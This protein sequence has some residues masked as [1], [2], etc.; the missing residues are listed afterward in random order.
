M[1]KQCCISNSGCNLR[2]HRASQLSQRQQEKLGLGQVAAV[3]PFSYSSQPAT[4]PPSISC[5]LP[6]LD[7]ETL[8]PLDILI[9]NDPTVKLIQ[10]DDNER[11]HRECE[12]Q[13][14]TQEEADY[15]QAIA[16]SLGVPY[17]TPMT[18]APRNL[19]SSSS[20]STAAVPNTV[21]TIPY[22]P[23]KITQHLNDDWMRPKNDHKNKARRV[24]KTNLENRFTVIFWGTVWE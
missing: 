4:P 19:A 9:A 13:L 23:P 12:A 20:T 21:R 8:P 11:I 5:S 18:P 2:D 16:N 17:I 24:V 22:G 15:Q 6:S 1:C 10:R 3:Q 7:S 14:A